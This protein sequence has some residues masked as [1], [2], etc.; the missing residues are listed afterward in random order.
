[1]RV[2]RTTLLVVAVLAA[3]PATSRAQLPPVV[4]DPVRQVVDQL[5]RPSATRCA[6][7][8]TSCRRCP[9]SRRRRPSCR[10]PR[11]CRR[12]RRPPP[13]RRRRPRGPR[14]RPRTAAPSGAGG[15]APRGRA[16]VG[17]RRDAAAPACAPGAPPRS[18]HRGARP[19]APGRAARRRGARR[20]LAARPPRRT[21]PA[22]V[23]RG[24][25]DQRCAARSSAPCRPRSCGRWRASSLIAIALA[26]NAYWQS[27][28]RDR[29]RGAARRAA[30]RHRPALARAAAGHAR[31][32]RRR[33]GVGGLPARRRARGRRRL[34]RRLHARRGAHLRAAR[35]RV[36]PRPRIGDAGGARPLH[37]AHAAGGRPPAGGGAGARRRA[38]RARAA[39]Q[40]RDRDRRHLRPRDR[41]ADLR[42][43]RPCAAD[44]PRD[45]PRS[46]RRGARAADRAR[47]RRDVAGVPRAA[48]R[49]RVG[50]PVHRRAADAQVGDDADRARRGRAVARGARR[51]GRRPADRR[52]RGHG[53]PH[54]AT[55]PPRWCSR[56]ERGS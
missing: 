36:R 25:G 19:P 5:P 1:M 56:A 44:R 38:A 35:R 7:S 16:A 14:R 37:A 52:P 40:L 26:I 24:P 32:A 22:A 12:R 23:V 15:H 34:L 42:E 10:S 9:C 30:G 39:A 45:R 53:R 55:T 29:A 2:F 18:R 4:G 46:R 31:G 8:W 20:A 41:R 27:R 33:R 17:A 11:R 48:G 43:G 47:G 50:V 49:G 28:R 3:G 21:G 13:R 54:G 6:G 51:P